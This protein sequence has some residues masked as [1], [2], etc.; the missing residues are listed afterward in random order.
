METVQNEIQLLNQDTRNSYN[1]GASSEVMNIKKL[2]AKTA[3]DKAN[4]LL[5]EAYGGER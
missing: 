2:A 4:E 3:V 1:N 5:G